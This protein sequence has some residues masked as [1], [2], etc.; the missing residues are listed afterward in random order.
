MIKFL[1]VLFLIGIAVHLINTSFVFYRTF[2]PTNYNIPKEG[3]KFVR[4]WTLLEIAIFSIGFILIV[5]NF[6]KF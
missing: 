5:C 6:D 3:A 4:V 2:Y 1:T